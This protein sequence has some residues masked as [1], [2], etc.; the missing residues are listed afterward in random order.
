M[1]PNAGDRGAEDGVGHQHQVALGPCWAQSLRPAERDGPGWISPPF[2]PS[3]A[4]RGAVRRHPRGS[5]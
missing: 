1:T 5:Y 3:G 2:M 4:L